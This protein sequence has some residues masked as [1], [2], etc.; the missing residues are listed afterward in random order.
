MQLHYR[1]YGAGEPLIVL[2]GLF[3]SH[4]NWQ[5]FSRSIG[6]QFKVFAVDQRNHGDSPRSFEMNYPAMAEDLREF[7][8]AQGLDQANMLGHSMGGKTVMRFAL[9]Y[10]QSV[11]RLVVA[12]ISPRAYELRHKDILE[13]LLALE[14]ARYSSRQEMEAALAPAIR[15]PDVRRF[16][17]KSVTRGPDGAFVWKLG[18]KEIDSNYARLSAAIS[19]TAPFGGPS[20]FIRGEFSDYLLPEDQPDVRALFPQAEFATVPGA[21]HWLQVENPEAFRREVKGFLTR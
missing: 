8:E 5:T 17:L 16:L 1:V 10:P 20:L 13:A 2:H 14:P 12:D 15:E 6:E 3:G 21:G 7:L 18:L 19:A 9:D 4:E 11:K